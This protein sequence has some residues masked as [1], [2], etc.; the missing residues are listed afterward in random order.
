MDSTKPAEM[1]AKHS[2]T[3]FNENGSRAG[4]SGFTFW[5]ILC[6][7]V[8]DELIC[9]SVL[10]SPASWYRNKQIHIKTST[11]QQAFVGSSVCLIFSLWKGIHILLIKNIWGEKLFVPDTAGWLCW[12]QPPIFLQI[13]LDIHNTLRAAVPLCWGPRSSE[14][15]RRDLYYSTFIIWEFLNRPHNWKRCA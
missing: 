10:S 3:S 5:Y 12:N 11:Y 8:V 9:R 4:G 1:N 2:K 6:P 13:S 15:G 7:G 14:T